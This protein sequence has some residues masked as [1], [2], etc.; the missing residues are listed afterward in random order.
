MS[1]GWCSVVRWP[2]WPDPLLIRET[3]S[4][5]TPP[6]FGKL[7]KGNVESF[8]NTIIEHYTNDGRLVPQECR[9]VRLEPFKDIILSTFKANWAV[10]QM[11]KHNF[12]IEEESNQTLFQDLVDY[13]GHWIHSADASTWHAEGSKCEMKSNDFLAALYDDGVCGAIAMLYYMKLFW[14]WPRPPLSPTLT[15]TPCIAATVF[16]DMF[17]GEKAPYANSP[18]VVDA[19]GSIK[20]DALTNI[21]FYTKMFKYVIRFMGKQYFVHWFLSD[22]VLSPEYGP[23]PSEMFIEV[24]TAIQQAVMCLVIKGWY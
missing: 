16:G 11:K 7:E 19:T 2:T 18:D 12:M 14:K 21:L 13:T 9:V 1:G 20:A 17:F 10:L 6:N 3:F 23:E 15:P 24:I 5:E 8:V 22:F 4:P